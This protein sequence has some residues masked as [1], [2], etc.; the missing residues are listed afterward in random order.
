[1]RRLRATDD[2]RRRAPDDE[3]FSQSISRS[4]TLSFSQG[5]SFW[6]R[7][8]FTVGQRACARQTA[9]ASELART[10][11]AKSNDHAHFRVIRVFRGDSFCIVD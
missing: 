5:F 2:N 9:L 4:F 8:V 1:M 11:E 10:Y 3:L 6:L 7:N